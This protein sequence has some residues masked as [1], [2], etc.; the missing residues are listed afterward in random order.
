MKMAT[1][2][3]YKKRTL[4]LLEEAYDANCPIIKHLHSQVSKLI[5]QDVSESVLVPTTTVAGTNDENSF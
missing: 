1:L 3:E 2:L 4:A 5:K